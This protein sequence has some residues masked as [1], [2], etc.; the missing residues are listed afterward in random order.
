LLKDGT[1]GKIN[2]SYPGKKGGR[3]FQAVGMTETE[4]QKKETVEITQVITNGSILLSRKWQDKGAGMGCNIQGF[5][6]PCYLQAQYCT[7]AW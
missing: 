2:G 7:F 4:E 6:K 1:F 3:E 5:P